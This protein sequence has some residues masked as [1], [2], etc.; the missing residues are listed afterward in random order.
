MQG[1]G[2]RPTVWRL[3]TRLGLAGDVFN[4]AEGVLIRIAAEAHLP[5]GLSPICEAEC[6]PLARIDAV[7][8]GEAERLT[9][10]DEFRIAES[11]TRGDAH[12]GRAGRGDLS[13]VPGRDPRSLCAAL[14]LSFHQLHPL[15]AA[16][17]DHLRSAL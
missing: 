15:R 8:S 3:A 5:S 10:D 16:P 17:V 1:V 12:R 9:I 14:S 6:P 4:D 2:F 11:E 13:G 7:E